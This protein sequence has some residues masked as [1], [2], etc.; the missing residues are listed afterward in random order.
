[1]KAYLNRKSA[2]AKSDSLVANIQKVWGLKVQWFLLLF[3]G[4]QAALA[5]NPYQLE[6]SLKNALRDGDKYYFDLYVRQA[7]AQPIFLAFSDLAFDI[8]PNQAGMSV[9]YV[10]GSVR[11]QSA[12]GLAVN[13]GL[14]HEYP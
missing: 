7:G 10:A 5:N 13:F 8:Q 4:V 12:S 2:A 6:V 14:R 11:L 3:F 1:M 9:H